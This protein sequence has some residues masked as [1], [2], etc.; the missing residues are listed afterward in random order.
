[1]AKAIAA[2]RNGDE[3]QARVFWLK[4][5]ELRTNDYVKSVTLESDRV[6]FVDDVVVSYSEPIKDRVTG[7]REVVYEFF[8]CKYHMT[9]HG[10]FTHEN[11]IDPRFISNQNSM[12]KRLY[13]AYVELSEKLHPD[14]YRLYIFSNWHWANHD[15][16]AKHLHEEMIRPTFYEN[17]PRSAA[18]QVRSK[19]AAHLSIS[20]EELRTFLNTVR[21]TLGKNLVDLEREM[22]PRLKL[23]GLQPIDQTVTHIPYDSL[24]WELFAQ[25]RNL[26]D[27]V[28]FNQMIRE[29]KLMALP[30]TKHSEISIQSFGQFARRPSDLQVA[31]LDLL[32]LFDERFPI[33][34]THWKKE[35]PEK[36]SAFMLD[37]KLMDVPQPIHIFF[38][39]HLSIAFFAGHLVSP[40][41]RIQ[42]IPTQKNGSDYELWKQCEP[43]PDTNLW[44][45]QTFGKIDEEV[46]VE[47]SV[48]HC[49]QK[50]MQVYLSAEGYSELPQ[51][52]VAPTGEIGPTA[53][54]GGT[55]A[56]Q[57]GYQLAE[58][59]RE[60]LPETCQ[61][62]HLFFA[63]PVA[64]AY[65]FGHTLRYITPHIQL[66]EYDFEG[67][68]GG[69]TYYP[70]LRITY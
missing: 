60:I 61:T 52:R 65:V 9:Q 70:S 6:S 48:T 28:A 54:S 69:R 7:K 18:G 12:L 8:Q 13:D 67:Q 24:A 62:V 47:I 5:L 41:H 25:G 14:A 15:T 1:M 39:C 40:K 49:I 10:A 51:I 11:L 27:E 19:L 3:Y 35:I 46:I 63:G 45:F 21:F 56:W 34:D 53:V 32:S 64:L 50:Q 38:D 59:L 37:P 57:L 36:I 31:R 20:E 43:D 58:Q 30:A 33:M 68:R 42:I 16:L 26:F 17:G 22:E 44:R 4:L 55:H 23:A 29:E 2:R 66:Y